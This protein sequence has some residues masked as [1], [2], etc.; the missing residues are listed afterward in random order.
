[1]AELFALRPLAAAGFLIGDKL[2]SKSSLPD[3]LSTKV[4][5]KNYRKPVFAELGVASY[6]RARPSAQCSE[7]RQ[8]TKGKFVEINGFIPAFCSYYILV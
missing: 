4:A 5:R 8:C 2:S 1:M 3:I 6:A 7:V